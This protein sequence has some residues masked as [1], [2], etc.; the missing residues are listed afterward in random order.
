[1]E[2]LVLKN[3]GG[4]GRIDL[5]RLYS[6]ECW[7]I[8]PSHSYLAGSTQLTSYIR[9]RLLKTTP[10][11]PLR[12]GG[13]ITRN[14]I[15]YEGYTVNYWYAGNGVIL[16]DYTPAKKNLASVPV[17]APKKQP[18]ITPAT[19]PLIGYRPEE[20]YDPSPAETGV[21]IIGIVLFAAAVLLAPATG[22]LSL[23]FA[24]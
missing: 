8:K 12:R 16:Y 2:V 7:E 21:V 22:G 9:G 15:E 14:T 17:P 6:G 5:V 4:L 24:W 23:A 11:I 18:K 19:E 10:N 13:Y 20:E 3:T 1:M